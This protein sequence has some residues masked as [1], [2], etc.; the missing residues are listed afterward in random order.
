LSRRRQYTQKL[1]IR[2]NF[3]VIKILTSKSWRLKILQRIFAEPAP[4]KA[5]R[6]VGEGGTS[7]NPRFSRNEPRANRLR[8]ASRKTIF[9]IDF[10]RG[11]VCR[12]DVATSLPASQVRCARP[13]SAPPVA[14]QETSGTLPS[15][16]RFLP[17]DERSAFL[18][19]PTECWSAPHSSQT[20]PHRRVRSW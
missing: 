12:R 4:V 2:P 3:F 5:F 20:P 7:L 9:V 19:A 11:K 8:T 18:D 10:H 13:L 15:L 16:R 1:Q 6:G 17:R 14:E